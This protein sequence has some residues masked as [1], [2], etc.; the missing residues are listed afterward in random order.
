MPREPIVRSDANDEQACLVRKAYGFVTVKRTGA[1]LDLRLMLAG[2][3]PGL[4]G[5]ALTLELMRELARQLR[6]G[7]PPLV[8]RVQNQ[9]L[10]IDPRTL[11]E[12][13]VEGVLEAFR[14]L[15]FDSTS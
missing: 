4:G 14:G 5:Q 12:T 10:L 11:A 7:D 9:A 6:L 15:K 1:R 8:V 13:E 3:W 2:I